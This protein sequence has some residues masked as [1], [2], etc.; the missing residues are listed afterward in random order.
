MAMLNI[1]KVDLSMFE[2]LNPFSSPGGVAMW[3]DTWRTSCNPSW[4]LTLSCIL[5]TLPSCRSHDAKQ[6]HLMDLDIYFDMYIYIYINTYII[7]YFD[8]YIYTLQYILIY[9]YNIHTWWY[10]YIYIHDIFSGVYIYIHYK[11]LIYIYIYTLSYFD[12]YIYI[13]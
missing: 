8:I 6:N 4:T 5:L 10:I 12:M 11:S 13:Y 2:I 9:I 1:Q 3:K 7:I